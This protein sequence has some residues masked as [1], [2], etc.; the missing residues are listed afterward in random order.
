MEDKCKIVIV[1]GG[2][3]GKTCITLRYLNNKFITHYDPTI[4]ES[5]RKMTILDGKPILLEIL[6]TAGQDEF[7]SVRDKY[8][9]TGEGFVIVYSI[10]SA[11]SLWEAQSFH[12]AI[13]KVKDTTD[14]PSLTVGNKSDLESQRQVSTSEG[15]ELAQKFRSQFLE[16]SAKSGKNI[17]QVFETIARDVRNWKAKKSGKNQSNKRNSSAISKKKKN[18]EII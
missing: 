14:T 5:Y 2:S 11:D 6:D 17:E 10:T 16:V 3:V 7:R 1:G 15:Q 4:E 18:C 8:L 9:R 13:E 12:E